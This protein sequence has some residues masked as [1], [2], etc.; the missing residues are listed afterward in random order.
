MN[1][2]KIDKI[3]QVIGK[4]SGAIGMHRHYSSHQ[5]FRKQTGDNDTTYDAEL[6][7]EKIFPD[8]ENCYMSLK[9]LKK[10]NE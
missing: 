7:F 10:T 3:E 2:K 5:K 1:D 8:I 9:K 6:F 4:L